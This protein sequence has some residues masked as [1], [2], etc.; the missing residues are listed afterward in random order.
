[1]LTPA[2]WAGLTALALLA[3]A[4]VFALVQVLPRA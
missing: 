4:L 3:A 2:G 1:M